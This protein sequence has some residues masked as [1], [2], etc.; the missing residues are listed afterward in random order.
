[1]RNTYLTFGAPKLSEESIAEVVDSLRSGW[2]GT[3]PKVARF[4]DLFRDYTG[5]DHAIA[6]NSCTAAL[7]L[8]LVA[9]GIG[10]GDEVITTP[11]T[12][13][14][15]ANAIVHA[16]AK[17]VF[18]DCDRDTQ[19]IDPALIEGA[20]TARTRAIVPVH[21]AGRMCD[22]RAI[23]AIAA[24]HDLRVVEDAAH[25]LESFQ[26]LARH[27]PMSDAACF[28]FYVT[29]NITTGEGG[30]VITQSSAVADRIKTLALHGMTRDAWQR[31]SDAGYRHYEVTEPG[32]KY[33]MMDIQAAIGIHQFDHAEIWLERRNEIWSRYVDGLQ[34]LP[35]GLPAADDCT[36]RHSR[37]LFTLMIDQRTSGIDRDSFI[38][39]MHA[40]NIG[41]GV[42]Y[43]GVHL[44][45]YYR[46]TFGYRPDDFPNASWISDRTVS[47][48][49]SPHLSD[50]EV[51]DVIAA[52]TSALTT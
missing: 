42:H 38:A 7:H 11:M 28:S 52:V 1:M 41:T 49:L 35:V 29:K 32:F 36:T 37:H 47:L 34:S 48:P 23:G 27:A 6:V 39:R 12:F 20:I 9:L 24:R 30:M 4:E 44:Q 10:P 2:I 15:T 14:A 17:P 43:R 46:E 26:R 19:L 33:N 13:A 18:V 25:S 8:S 5:A 16:G 22:M 3:G 40:L 31:F 50:D 21:L 51:D 45:P